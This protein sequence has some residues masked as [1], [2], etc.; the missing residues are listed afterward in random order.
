[1]FKV[2][3]YVHRHIVYVFGKACTLSHKAAYYRQFLL[4]RM[5]L[6]NSPDIKSNIVVHV[7]WQNTFLY[8]IIRS[9]II[10]VHWHIIY[11]FGKACILS[12]KAAYYR[13]CFLYLMSLQNGPDIK[14]NIVV[15]VDWQNT[16]LYYIIRSN[17]IVVHWHIVYVFGKACT[18]SHK[19]A[20]WAVCRCCQPDVLLFLTLMEPSR[21]FH[22][23]PSLSFPQG[24][25]PPIG[26]SLGEGLGR[27]P[28]RGFLLTGA[29]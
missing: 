22:T 21:T 12:H 2:S 14:S 27:F 20:Y 29:L 13:Q 10:V 19:A 15:Q 25:L 8:Y 9:N 16:F 26:W 11:V 6:Q 3:L 7:D 28:R 1:M 4:Y 18:L 17:I 5:S 24:W 23:L